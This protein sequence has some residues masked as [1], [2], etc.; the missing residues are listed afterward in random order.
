MVIAGGPQTAQGDESA[1]YRAVCVQLLH[2][3]RP[4]ITAAD[5][6]AHCKAA[7]ETAGLPMTS[8]HVG[9][10]LTR[11]AGHENPILHP[12]CDLPLEAGMLV[13]GEPTLMPR[14]A[15]RRHIAESVH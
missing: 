2:F 13:P 10:S 3:I 7:Y 14:P 15:H 9:H 5:V 12:G 6:Y 8:P 11:M 4:G 1:R